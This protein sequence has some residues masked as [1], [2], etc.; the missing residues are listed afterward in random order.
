M[1]KY[2]LILGMLVSLVYAQEANMPSKA[3]MEKMMAG[4]QEMQA[5]MAKVDKS[6]LQ[7][8][9]ADAMKI[10]SEVEGM[11]KKGQRSKAQVTA[12]T[13]A[14]KIMKNPA[15]VQMKK[16][17]AGFVPDTNPVEELKKQHVCDSGF[18]LK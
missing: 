1:K 12:L 2:L 17:T 15:L 10:K 3:D 11:C 5:C 4:M 6:S 7:S 13:Y 9:Q 14:K 16:C 8:M 18:D